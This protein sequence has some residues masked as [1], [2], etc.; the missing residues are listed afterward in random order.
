MAAARGAGEFETAT[1]G[2]GAFGM[3][4]LATVAISDIILLLL[5]SAFANKDPFWIDIVQLSCQQSGSPRRRIGITIVLA[6]R[7]GLLKLPERAWNYGI[8]MGENGKRFRIEAVISAGF[9]RFGQF[10]YKSGRLYRNRRIV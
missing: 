4:I 8:E 2:S 10:A 5:N 9:I 3:T 6:R 1:T 7:Y